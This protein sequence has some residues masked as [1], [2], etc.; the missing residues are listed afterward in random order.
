MQSLSI[1][2]VAPLC[3]QIASEYEGWSYV[4]EHFKYPIDKHSTLFIEPLWSHHISAQPVVVL[5]N[6]KAAKLEKQALSD[7]PGWQSGLCWVS[8]KTILAPD[9]TLETQVYQE[10]V[11]NLTEAEV[12]IRDFFTRG[13]ALIEQHYC[14]TD[15]EELL[16]KMPAYLDGN[17]G[18]NYCLSRIVLH[19]FDFAYRYVNDEIKTR[20]PKHPWVERIKP[21]I[22]IWEE[23]Y[24]ATGSVFAK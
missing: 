21:Y 19:D 17:I 14:Y 10:L 22:P 16:T 4:A 20:R 11:H 18:I 23:N 6:K 5:T 15:E 24:R 8:K 3:K 2:D 9:A 1:K 7:A 13:L 12:Y